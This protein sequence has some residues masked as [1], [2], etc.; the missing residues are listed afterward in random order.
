MK[1]F[2][3]MLASVVVHGGGAG[4]GEGGGEGETSQRCEV[5]PSY[6]MRLC[7]QCVERAGSG[8]SK[9]LPRNT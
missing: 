9:R 4:M 5:K 6:A 2:V 7:A 8:H 1:R 3:I